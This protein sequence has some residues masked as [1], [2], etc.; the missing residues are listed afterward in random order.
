[1]TDLT[2][3]EIVSELDRFIIGQND[4]KRAVAV[5]LRN[6]WRR[7]QLGDDLRD[8]VY[9]KN[10]LMIGPTGVG[11]TEISRRLAKLARAPFLKVEATKFTE[12]GY[13]GRD[14]EQI[15]RDLIDSAIVMTREHMREDVKVSAH[16]AAEERVVDA[17]AGKDAREGTRD[18]FRKKLKAG[19]L[20]DT[21]IELEVA[22]TSSPFPT[23]DIPGQP[24]GGMGMMN[25]GDL[26]GKAMGGRT[27]K[28]RLSVSE[29]YEV[30]ISEEADK[31]LD[32]ETVNRAAIESVE[33]NGIVF[34]D[35]IDK[36]CARSDARG[37]DVSREG[38]QRDLLPLIEGTTVSTKHGPVKTDHILF[39]ASGAFHIAKPSDLLPELQGRLP[40]RVELRA[41]T[42]DDFVRILTETDNALTLQYTALMGTEEVE[43]TFT[44]EGIKAL[45]KIAADVNQSIENI[46]ARRLYTVMERVFEE[47]SFSAPDRTGEKITVDGDF[48]EKNLGELTRSTDLSRYVL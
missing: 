11:K 25:I 16:K 26:F 21:M 7:K 41:L 46:G 8:E 23:M 10:I 3:R 28:K 5:A 30:L 19:E 39:I 34:L 38:V 24:G 4:A 48:V 20:D 32:D 36:V 37:G 40:I 45:A 42:E 43:V 12:V 9:P 6:R 27:V 15:I 29:S 13:V 35:E 44:D 2:P 33:Q 1:M 17:I 31:L 18:M 47:L 14:V 22:D